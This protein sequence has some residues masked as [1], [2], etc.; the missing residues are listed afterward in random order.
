MVDSSPKQFDVV[1][2]TYTQCYRL[3]VSLPAN[4]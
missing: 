2:L 1:E 3:A 4:T